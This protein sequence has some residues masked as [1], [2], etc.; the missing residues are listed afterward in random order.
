M[1]ESII[2]KKILTYLNSLDRSYFWKQAAGPFS[3]VGASDL[4]GLIDG[5]L[6]AFEVKRPGGKTTKMQLK[7]I[8]RIRIAGGVATVVFSVEDVK[9]VVE[10]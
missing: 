2:Q 3:V 8:D 5:K 6:Y 7:F 1:K 10:G 9:E 4:V